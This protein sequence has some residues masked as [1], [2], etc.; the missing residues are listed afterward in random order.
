VIRIHEVGPR[1]GLQNERT[2]VPTEGKLALIDALVSAGLRSIEATSFVSPKAVPQMAD[3]EA[4]IGGTKKHDGVRRS[5]LVLNEKGY[6]RAR[7]AGCTSVVVVVVVSER[8][9]ARNSR[10]T[11]AEGIAACRAIVH[12][13]ERDGVECRVCLAPCWV[14]P[15]EGAIDSDHVL[16]CA[17]AVFSPAVYELALADTIGHATPLAVGRLFERFGKRFGSDKLAAHL[18]DT[19]AFGLANAAAALSAGVRTFDASVGG[20]GG[21]P[22]A[23]GAA[24]NLATEDIV[25]LAEKMGMATGVDLEKLWRAVALAESLVGRTIGGRTRAYWE[26]E[27]RAV[28]AP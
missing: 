17:E 11:V 24:G 21:C 14:C 23:P 7:E 10:M 16:A 22:F 20:L 25:L 4:V 1:D 15:F 13:A 19:L 8:L 26:R 12:R 6:E 9:S 27:T 2:H 28:T 5:A 18:H 3:A